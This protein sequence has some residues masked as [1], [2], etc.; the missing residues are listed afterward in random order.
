MRPK[1]LDLIA[2]VFVTAIIVSNIVASKIGAFGSYFLPVGVVI[3]PV[4]YILGD[5]LTEVYGFAAMRRVIWIGFLCNLIA[6][7]TYWIARS[8]PSA[9]FY[10]DQAAFDTIFGATPR[11]LG[12]SFIAYLIGS[13]TNSFIIAKMKIRTKGKHLWMRTISSTVIGEGI[14][15]FVF[16]AVAFTGVFESAQIH[17]LILT[18]WIFKSV[19]EIVVTPLTYVIVRFLKK[20]EGIDHF[21]HKTSFS[22]FHF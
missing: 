15:S 16:I 20:A 10:A 9:P 19:V 7:I 8:I 1:Y 2:A 21:D 18:Q 13:F 5:I 6:V 14:D 22:P 11:L 12:A 3:F 4:A 17:S